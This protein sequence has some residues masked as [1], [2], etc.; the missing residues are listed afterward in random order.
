MRDLVILAILPFLLY[1]MCK[2]PFIG[3]GL[4]I[5]TALF[6]PNGWLYGPAASI[7]YNLLFAGITVVGYFVWKNKPKFTLTR[8]GALI[9]LF[10]AWTTAS[11]LMGIGDPE[12]AWDFWSR[13][14]KTVMLFV[15][16]LAIIENKLHIDFFLWCCVLSVGFFADLEALKYLMSGGGHMIEGMTGHVLGDRNELSIA[17]VMTLPICVYLLQ[18][19]G[20]RSKILSLALLGTITLMVIAVIG[21]QSRGGFIVLIALGAYFYLK[22]ERKGLVTVLLV[23]LVLGMSQLVT[24]EWVTRIQTVNSADKDASFMGRVVAWKLS[25]IMASQ[26]PFFG[27]GFKALENFPVWSALSQHFDSVPWFYTGDATPDLDRPHAAHSVYFQVMGDHGFVGLGIYLS[28][29]AAA[30]Q[31]ARNIIRIARKHT[32]PEWIPRLATTLQ[33][34]MFAFCLGGA[35]LSFAYFEMA[36]AVIGLLIVLESR[37]LPAAILESEQRPDLLKAA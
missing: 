10:F 7:R 32:V 24:Q 37:I 36:Y 27:G 30:F 16:I 8:T 14:L 6:F 23:I 11:T 3:L 31:K 13:L 20:K 33:L 4:W 21:T 26:H 18:D 35:S 34:T 22:T 2:R 15:F 28:F 1:A 12:R 19:F 29:L 25:F 9:L 5:W 17:F